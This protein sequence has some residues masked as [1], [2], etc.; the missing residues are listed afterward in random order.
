MDGICTDQSQ[1]EGYAM[2]VTKQHAEQNRERVLDVASTLFR[3]RGFD[4][5]SVAELM[6]QAGL[7][8]GGFYGQFGS[9]DELMAEALDRAFD[10]ALI[11][12]RNVAIEAEKYRAG[13]A[14]RVVS[15]VY[16][17]PDHCEQVGTGCVM[18]ALATDA[19]RQSPS[20][21]QRMTQGVQRFAHAMAK[22]F[23]NKAAEVQREKA[24]AMTA[25]LVGALMLARAVDDPTLAE[26]ILQ[27]TRKVVLG[28]G[29]S[30]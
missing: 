22:L 15:K 17:S 6:K 30:D 9:K 4:G 28:M 10:D 3:E 8:H 16:L 18:A 5:I 13:S 26:D 29:E 7:T 1:V 21:R 14:L 19:V 11:H 2:R 25:S 24:L 23:P 27:A 12:W 20:V